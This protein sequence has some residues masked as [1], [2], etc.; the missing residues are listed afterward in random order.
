VSSATVA[1][2]NPLEPSSVRPRPRNPWTAAALTVVFGPLAL[3]YC[4]RLRRA[5][6]WELSVVPLLI[7]AGCLL[8]Y[9]PNGRM[10]LLA[11]LVLVIGCKLGM[12][13]D[14][15]RIARRREVAHQWYQRWWFYLAFFIAAEFFVGGFLHLCRTYWEEAFYLPAGSMENTLFAGDRILVDKLQYRF[16]SVAP[17]D[18]VVFW[19][20]NQHA[21]VDIP[22]DYPGRRL[23]VKR[24]IG[25]P[26]DK[27]EIR[28]EKLFRNGSLCEEDYVLWRTRQPGERDHPALHDTA[29]FTL[30]DEEYFVL[31]DNR[32]SSFDSR[33][34]GPVKRD[35]I[36]GK[37]EL[38]YWSREAPPLDPPD[39]RPGMEK[40]PAPPRKIRWE[41]IGQRIK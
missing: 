32:R 8:M 39:F 14:A 37:V 41:R 15:V 1:D 4:G 28:D 19:S 2:A 36:I 10:A 40:P 5:V 12:I 38:V 9:L 34:F 26:G 30:G 25:I 6:V 17:G 29:E 27:I 16:D 23:L 18:V 35:D 21:Y 7:A 13:I 33:M 20:D 11:G 3:V 24:V 31:G 22:G